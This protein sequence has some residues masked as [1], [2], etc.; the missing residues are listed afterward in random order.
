MR[1]PLHNP[2]H[3]RFAL[4]HAKGATKTDA[5]YEAFGTK[6][7]VNASKLA[8]RPEVRSRIQHLVKTTSED[9]I[10]QIGITKTGL[11]RG[12]VDMWSVSVVEVEVAKKAWDAEEDKSK[13]SPEHVRVLRLANGIRHSMF[14]CVVSLPDKVSVAEKIAR[15]A[16]WYAEDQNGKDS[17]GAAAKGADALAEI[18]ALAR[19]KG[20]LEQPDE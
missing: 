19:R 4:A 6:S 11:L 15:I 10:E 17:A 1:T 2:R 13:V 16:G 7:R 12:L 8:A 9:A 18:V 5:Y 14:G 3:E 20:S